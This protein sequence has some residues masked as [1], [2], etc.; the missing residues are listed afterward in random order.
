[1]P[2]GW[3]AGLQGQQVT[4][5]EDHVLFHGSQNCNVYISRHQT[6]VLS[7]CKVR[8]APIVGD[9]EHGAWQWSSVNM[10]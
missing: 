3:L 2:N 9:C 1:M 7:F 10:V 4:S 6:F 8:S 5:F